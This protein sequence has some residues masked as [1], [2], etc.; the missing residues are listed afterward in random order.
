VNAARFS[1]RDLPDLSGRTAVVTGASSGIGIETARGLAAAGA[2]V[3]LAVR[4]TGKGERVAAGIAGATEVRPLDLADLASVRAFA[5]GWS[6]PLDL[7]VNNAG[8][9]AVPQGRTADGFELHIGTNHLGHFALTALLWPHL[10]GRVV[11]VSSLAAARGRIDLA[12]LNWEQRRYRPWGAYCQ[13]KLANLLFTY[14]LNLR[15]GEGGGG[16]IA[17][18]AHPGFVA[19]PL[20]R[21]TASRIQNRLLSPFTR[22]VAQRPAAG[23]LPTLYAATQDLP[24]GA[25]VGPDGGSRMRTSPGAVAPPPAAVD[26]GLARTLWQ[27]SAELTGLNPDRSGANVSGSNE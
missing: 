26:A 11:T 17:L 13:S 20:Q 22:L 7:L 23:A 19:T 18:S 1:A 6:G 15:L 21:H 24:G 9:M 14:E 4:D 8:I 2:D 12:D 25:Y 16:A 5:A 10:R 3:V 27:L